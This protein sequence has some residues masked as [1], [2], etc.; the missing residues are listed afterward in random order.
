MSSGSFNVM[1]LIDGVFRLV[2][3]FFVGMALGYTAQLGEETSWWFAGGTLAVLAIFFFVMFKLFWSVDQ[4]SRRLLDWASGVKYP[5]GIKPAKNPAP[6][7]KPHWF[8]RY[9]WIPALVL[10]A[11]AVYVLPEEVLAWLT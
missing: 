1:S 5:G 6:E 9:G 7:P 11:L 4:G 8:V 10:G 3:G 2:I